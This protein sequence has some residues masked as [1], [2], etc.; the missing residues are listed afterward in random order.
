MKARHGQILKKKEP[1]ELEEIAEVR[2]RAFRHIFDVDMR[3]KR[4]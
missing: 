4:F 3:V 1:K 2:Q